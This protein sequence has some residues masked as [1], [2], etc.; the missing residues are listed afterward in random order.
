MWVLDKNN[1]KKGCAGKR[2]IHGVTTI[3]KPYM[4]QIFTKQ[5]K[6]RRRNSISDDDDI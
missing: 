3:A 1:G 2:T 5:E 4:R 6:L